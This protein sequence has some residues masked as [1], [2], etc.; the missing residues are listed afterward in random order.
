MWHQVA[1]KFE[2]SLHL[3]VPSFKWVIQILWNNIYFRFRPTPKNTGGYLK[4]HIYS[5]YYIT[6]FLM[7]LSASFIG[8][9]PNSVIFVFKV[10]RTSWEIVKNRKEVYISKNK[11]LILCVHIFIKFPITETLF[12]GIY[13]LFLFFFLLFSF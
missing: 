6:V 1:T 8:K 4:V 3:H 13:F 12:K 2:D 7:F 9:K 11:F 5:F 10:W